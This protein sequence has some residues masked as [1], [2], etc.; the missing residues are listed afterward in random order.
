MRLTVIKATLLVITLSVFLAG[1]GFKLRDT[2]PL[3]EMYRVVGLSGTSLDDSFGKTLSNAFIDAR[4][5]L[6]VDKALP[7]QLIITTAEEGRRVASY[8]SDLS[9]RQYLVFLLVDYQI[10][11]SGK[12]VAEHRLKIDKTMNYDSDFVLGKQEEERQI[13]QAH[14]QE[15]ARLILL[16]LKSLKP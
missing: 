1:C 3:P 16:R 12:V 5:Q 7:T 6:V 9:V 15:A 8:G 2:T 10:V 13:Q 14:Q 4:S 11:V